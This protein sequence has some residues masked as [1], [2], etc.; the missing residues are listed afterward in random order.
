MAARHKDDRADLL[1]EHPIQPPQITEPGDPPPPPP[2]PEQRAN[3]KLLRELQAK[4]S[5]IELE[6]N[7][8]I[9]EFDKAEYFP[10]VLTYANF[11]HKAFLAE[12]NQANGGELFRLAVVLYENG[13]VDEA[14]R[15][16]ADLVKNGFESSG[17]YDLATAAAFLTE[18]FDEAIEWFP[19]AVRAGA[20]PHTAMVAPDLS[21]I[22]ICRK[23]WAIELER[24]AKDAAADDLPRIKLETEVG[25][26][27]YELFENEA[28]E[29]VA[30]FISLVKSGFYDNSEFDG[31][32]LTVAI[33]H[34]LKG[35]RE[36]GAGYSIYSEAAKA[37]RR[38]PFR[39]A[40]T[41]NAWGETG[42]AGAYSISLRGAPYA[43]G[44]KTTFGRLIEG[45]DVLPKIAKVF[46]REPQPGLKPTKV[47]K[48][49]VLRDRGHDYQPRKV[50]PAATAGQ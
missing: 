21:E 25:D 30:N 15:Y 16:V 27:V 36:K 6:L 29:T 37:E 33:N 41:M 7:V 50:E 32:S 47:L 9:I 48:A 19:L 46:A 10:A 24:R 28:P 5:K 2:T 38:F 42:D 39:G 22:E 20:T 3:A 45:F 43:D 18:H 11:C 14:Y 23:A 4:Q 13:N 44:Q 31:V 34:G 17:T 12:P 26:L 8:E 40:L 49:T 35:R 1:R